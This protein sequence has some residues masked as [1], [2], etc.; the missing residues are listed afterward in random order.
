MRWIQ[1]G[2][3]RELDLLAGMEREKRKDG[4]ETFSFICAHTCI[5][6]RVSSVSSHCKYDVYPFR[7][8]IQLNDCVWWPLLL[9]PNPC[10]ELSEMLEAHRS[11]TST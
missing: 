8:L 2:E 5:S 10:I 7:A 1:G 3:G 6:E 11:R 4:E 9:I